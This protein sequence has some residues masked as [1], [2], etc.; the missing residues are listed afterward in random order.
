MPDKPPD[1]G[2][3][4]W[5]AAWRPAAG[6]L[7]VYLDIDPAD[8]GEPWRIELKSGLREIAESARGALGDLHKEARA[9]AERVYERLLAAEPFEGRCQVGFIE[10]GREP[11]RELWYALQMDPGRTSLAHWERAHLLPMI[12]MIDEGATVGAVVISREAVR[13]FE[14]EM[15]LIEELEHRRDEELDRVDPPDR[16]TRM[17]SA[18]GRPSKGIPRSGVGPDIEERTEA[19]VE[20]FL[21][22]T[23]EGLARLAGE[24][25]WRELLVFGEK[26]RFEQLAHGFP[27]AHRPLL[28]EDRDLINDELEDIEARIE[29]GVTEFNRRREIDLVA[30]AREA[31]LSPNGHGCAGVPDT[32]EALRNARVEHL[33]L[34]GEPLAHAEPPP[35]NP[36]ES[37]PPVDP[38]GSEVV[39]EALIEQ[40]LLT[41]AKVTPT[42]REAEVEL[43]RLGGVAALLRY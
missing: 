3:L 18:R 6:V 30:R 14:W 1:E 11:G 26:V 15:G 12:K 19:D 34:S 10:V 2:T 31:A 21:K 32:L 35:T 41:G 29:A 25:G 9:T 28:C 38:I 4:K 22:R 23:G 13:V 20:R 42:E 17:G 8:R 33:V 5:L 37:E 36:N 16:G 40:A 43:T 7:S 39:Q 27:K 24:R